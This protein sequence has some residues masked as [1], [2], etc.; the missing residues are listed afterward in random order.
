MRLSRLLALSLFVACTPPC[1]A[2]GGAAAAADLSKEEIKER[3]VS[4]FDGK[5]LEGWQ[6]ATDGYVPDS[7]VLVCKKGG[8]LMTTKEYA[9]FIFRFE[10]KLEPGGNNGVGIRTPLEGNPAYLGMEIQIL[11][12]STDRSGRLKPF[13]YHG[14]IYGVVPAKRGHQKPHGEWNSEE[15]MCQGSRV[16]VTLN[17]AVIVDADLNEIGEATMD[18]HAHPGLKREKGYLGFLGHGSR[19]EFRNL[20]IKEL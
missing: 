9:D 14:S 20:R 6:G 13:Q 17:G 7:G 1:L 11:D 12:D 16:K 4:L 5:T 2:G 8:N 15:I 10:F 3:F 18:G 19:V